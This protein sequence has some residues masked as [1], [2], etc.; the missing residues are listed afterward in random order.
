M[1][2]SV[3]ELRRMLSAG[4]TVVQPTSLTWLELLKQTAACK[5]IC[6]CP[7][8][9]VTYIDSQ[10]GGCVAGAFRAV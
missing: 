6:L 8:T 4:C 5:K 1:Q 3:G 9:T 2:T 7:W 10:A